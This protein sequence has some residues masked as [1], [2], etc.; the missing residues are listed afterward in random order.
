MFHKNV[1]I[2]I[3]GDK[4]F[5]SKLTSLFDLHF[6]SEFDEGSISNKKTLSRH[7]YGLAIIKPPK[8]INYDPQ[9]D[10]FDKRITWLINY[11]ENKIELI[12]KHGGDEIII[13]IEYNLDIENI[14]Q[15]YIDSLSTEQMIKMGELGIKYEITIWPNFVTN[16]S[17]T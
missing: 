4:F 2:W 14:S 10:T 11:L 8:E 6:E 5:P 16:D 13:D 17:L 9:S 1:Q 12:K 7:T 15:K 3:T